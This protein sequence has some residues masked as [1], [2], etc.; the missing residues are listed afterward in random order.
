MDL[1]IPSNDDLYSSVIKNGL[2]KRI[3][4]LNQEISDDVIENCIMH[5]IYWNAE[6]KNLPSENRKPIKL[7]INS[8]GGDMFSAFGLINVIENSI[9]PVIA[10][11]I[12]LV[13]SAAYHIYLSCDERL[14]FND[15]VLL[16][17][18]GEIAIQNS[19]SKAKDV[20]RFYENMDARVKSHVLMHSSMPEDIY[21]KYYETELYMYPDKAKDWGIVDKIIGK[22][23]SLDYIL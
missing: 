14:S 12:G 20:M 11:G 1:L 17:H 21:D 18:D 16:Q 3:L 10:V 22:D 9:T 2:E 13:A 7:I 19:G 5:I 23:I 4:I 8:V 6:D 15:T